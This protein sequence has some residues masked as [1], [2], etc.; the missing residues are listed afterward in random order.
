VESVLT[1]AEPKVTRGM[2]AKGKSK[3]SAQKGG[4]KNNSQGSR[5]SQPA[6]QRPQRRR[7]EQ[8]NQTMRSRQSK[9]QGQIGNAIR[10][11]M[12]TVGMSDLIQHRI[13]WVAG[14]VYVGNGTLGATNSVYLATQNPTVIY[15]AGTGGGFWVPFAPADADVGATYASSIMRLYRRCRIR[16]AKVHLL[17]VQSSTTNNAVI[18]IAP[19]RGPPGAAE[20]AQGVT[21]T[22]AAQTLQNLMSVSG[23]LSCDSFENLTLDLTPYIAG[24]SGAQQN[25]FAIA[26][27]AAQTTD[28]SGTANV[29]GLVPC[30]FQVAGNSTV[31]ALQA[32]VTHNVV[33]EI[34]CDLLDFVGAIPVIDPEEFALTRRA[35]SLL[36]SETKEE[37]RGRLMSELSALVRDDKGKRDVSCSP[38]RQP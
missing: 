22:S 35:R 28:I 11:R 32:S 16:T 14:T 19:I 10:V 3:Q 36:V 25:E 8:S 1:S 26:N 38:V 20:F 2:P 29:L 9:T 5:Q 31:A 18:A 27:T 23:M 30:A 6:K 37:K 17:T 33:C 24:G 4:K 21:N 7:N 12:P 13:T 34:V 15:A